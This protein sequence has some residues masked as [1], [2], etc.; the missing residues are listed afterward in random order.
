M[1]KI[2]HTELIKIFDNMPDSMAYIFERGPTAESSKFIYAS[3]SAIN[4]YGIESTLIEE[5]AMN[6]ISMVK[7]EF[8]NSFA[9]SVQHSYETLENW[10]WVGI[11]VNNKT[12][13]CS[14]KPYIYSKD[15]DGNNII[16]WYGSVTDITETT[17]NLKNKIKAEE[18]LRVEKSI[19]DTVCHELRNPLNVT[20]SIF[21][22]T[23]DLCKKAKEWKPL[24]LP[25][26]EEYIKNSECVKNIINN[27]LSEEERTIVYRTMVTES[28]YII[29][30]ISEIEENI[31][32]GILASQQKL[33]VINNMLD[34]TH[35]EQNKLVLKNDTIDLYELCK[36]QVDMCFKISKVPVILECPKELMFGDSR[37]IS[38]ILTN[39]LN[40]ASKVT[41]VGYIKL[42]VNIKDNIVC[43][44]I[45]DT[46]CGISE[47][48]KKQILTGGRY[49][50]GG[51]KHGNGIGICL[52]RQILKL[53]NSQLEIISPTNEAGTGSIFKFEVKYVGCCKNET[54]DNSNKEI[55]PKKIIDKITCLLVDDLPENNIMLE[56]QIKK[57]CVNLF[58]NV[59]VNKLS[60]GEE[61]LEYLDSNEAPD[62]I[63]IDEVMEY[64]K[65]LGSETI[66][67]IRALENN[68]GANIK[69][70]TNSGNCTETDYK[71]YI[72]FGA[73][74][75]WGKPIP[76]KSIETDFYN[77]LLNI[78]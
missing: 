14:S 31:R 76:L 32:I 38:Q 51:F 64:R 19:I 78:I 55:I 3:P 6:I 34:I 1:S 45:E 63:V 52:I 26:N 23:N 5:N 58:N 67:K 49:E 16:R 50:H 61:C 18:E 53:M 15:T 48:K 29:D 37:Q 11:L 33:R 72:K 62:I 60:S 46:G 21:D 71:K 65:L 27:K 75:M 9:E 43:F 59:I 8:I 44:S 4:I 20:T 12:I 66:Q 68:K 57:R 74:H 39:I 30:L 25:I 69:I 2:D 41:L 22:I 56:K 17:E 42:K 77:L 40:N 54:N 10:N 47:S 70:I 36:S 7:E 13:K 35:L 28:K 24:S 73:N